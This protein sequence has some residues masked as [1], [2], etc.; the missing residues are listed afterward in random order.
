MEIKPHPNKHR[1]AIVRFDNYRER[2]SFGSRSP[3]L[4][5][6]ENLRWH[7]HVLTIASYDEDWPQYVEVPYRIIGH[8]VGKLALGVVPNREVNKANKDI[9]SASADHLSERAAIEYP[10]EAI[11]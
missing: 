1:K 4:S 8:V 10:E 6:R 9:L 7:A 3:Y 2:Y 5:S 11:F